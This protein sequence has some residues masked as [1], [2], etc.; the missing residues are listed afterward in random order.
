MS[1]LCSGQARAGEAGEPA[2]EAAAADPA[3]LGADPQLQEDGV[4]VQ[5]EIVR[6]LNICIPTL[7]GE[8]SA[9]DGLPSP[10]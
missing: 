9:E 3:H 4:K 6:P 10:S 1:L 2:G 5:P 8:T 7:R